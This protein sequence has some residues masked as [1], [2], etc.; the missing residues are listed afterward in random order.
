MNNKNPLQELHHLGQSV[1]L[2]YIRRDLLTSGELQNMV[3][4]GEV[5]GMTSNPSIFDK[6]I[7]SSN[8]YD[9][10]IKSYLKTYPNS[11]TQDL[12]EALVTQ[13]IQLAAEILYPIYEQ[14][15]QKNGYVSLEVSPKLAYDTE[16]TIRQ[17]RDLF[18][19]IN[20][21]NLMIKIPAK[22]YLLLRPRSQKV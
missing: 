13:D 21:P 11:T 6:A 1:W 9:E 4:A 10:A 15:N 16:G 3:E 19:A 5:S 8:L 17:A 12:Y 18:Q 2:D 7:S 22:G 14:S 20:H